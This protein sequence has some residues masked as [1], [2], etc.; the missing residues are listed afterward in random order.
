M[1]ETKESL[2]AADDGLDEEAYLITNEEHDF[3]LPKIQLSQV[4]GE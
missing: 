2:S 3:N 1:P 4:T